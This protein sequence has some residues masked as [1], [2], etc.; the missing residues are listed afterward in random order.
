MK[1]QL[2]RG[3]ILLLIGIPALLSLASLLA[4]LIEVGGWSRG[5]NRLYILLSHVCH[6]MPS[7]SLWVFGAPIGV[8]SRSLFLYLAFAGTG[9]FIVRFRWFL[10]WQKSLLLLMPILVD[11][12]TQLAGWRES[13]NLLRVLT[14]G[15]GGIGLAGLIIPILLRAFVAS[16][17]RP[18]DGVRRSN[19]TRLIAGLTLV[20]FAGATLPYGTATAQ[21]KITIPEG[22]R[23][24][25]KSLEGVSSESGKM[26]QTIRF[27]VV[28]DVVVKNKVVIKAGAPAIGEVLKAESKRAV[29]REGILLVGIRYA[30]AI[31]TT[32]V[33]VRASL[34]EKGEERFG[35]SIAL[36]IVLCPLFLLMKGKEAEIPAGT[37][38]T[39]FVDRPVEVT[40]EGA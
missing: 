30:T 22:T 8:C 23:V 38:Y 21:T 2:T 15:L 9:L 27:E 4:P 36:G 20:A 14:G 10:P 13:T 17:A 33:P 25:V 40:V 3:L 11:G 5:A 31:D 6:Q 19:L 18:E 35:L 37:E 12:L 24:A 39:V 29:G 34:E 26:G 7:R 16:A 32:Q 28:R 1:H